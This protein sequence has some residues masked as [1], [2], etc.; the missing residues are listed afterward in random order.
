MMAVCEV[1]EIDPQS[2]PEKLD[3]VLYDAV[4]PDALN[5]VIESCSRGCQIEFSW[6]RYRIIVT[7]EKIV[8]VYA[9]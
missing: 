7:N 9:C 2:A 1:N 5:A 6:E 4:N 8:E 3:S